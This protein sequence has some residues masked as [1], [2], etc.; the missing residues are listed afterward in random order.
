MKQFLIFALLSLFLTIAI[1]NE[2]LEDFVK[3]PQRTNQCYK[4]FESFLHSL[5]YR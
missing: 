1:A 3:D 5:G 4:K 2:T